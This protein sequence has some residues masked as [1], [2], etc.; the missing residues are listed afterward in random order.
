MR[1]LVITALAMLLFASIALN[2][3]LYER[4]M[5]HENL[6]RRAHAEMVEKGLRPS[7]VK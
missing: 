4:S 7:T 3:V 1:G 2:V 6:W 5:Y